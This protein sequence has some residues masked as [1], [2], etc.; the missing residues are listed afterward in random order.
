[1]VSRKRGARMSLSGSS[2]SAAIRIRGF[3]SGWT[4]GIFCLTAFLATALFVGCAAPGGTPTAS[5]AQASVPS[6][7]DGDYAP[8]LP[9]HHVLWQRA[10]S[11]NRAVAD[12]Y[13]IDDLIFVVGTDHTV[14]AVG[15]DGVHRW[16]E[17]LRKKPDYRPAM[18][19]EAVFF[20]AD[21]DLIVVSR[22]HGERKVLKRL[23]FTPAGPPAAGEN[24]VYLPAWDNHRIFAVD[25]HTGDEGWKYRFES[26]VVGRPV[27]VGAAPRQSLVAASEGGE[28][29]ALEALHHSATPKAAQWTGSTLDGNTAGL[30]SYDGDL[31]LVPSHDTNLYAYERITGHRRWAYAS[32][33]KLDRAAVVAG[34]RVFL[35]AAGGT[36]VLDVESG[37]E[38]WSHETAGRFIVRDEKRALLLN[39]ENCHVYTLDIATGEVLESNDVSDYAFVLTNLNDDG[40]L[41]LVTGNGEVLALDGDTPTQ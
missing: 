22:V 3:G 40:R 32:G 11:G 23:P 9:L 24:A 34:D 2:P 12:A 19:S 28:V 13:M 4:G 10:A 31:V 8:D 17:N 36:R 37:E 6:L 5:D 27:V 29:V 41:Y 35:P 39:E 1:M 25:P 33:V 20:V 16:V 26:P 30:T 21:G 7:I 38:L 14:N 18:N 15:D